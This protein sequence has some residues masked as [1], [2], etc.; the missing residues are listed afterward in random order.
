MQL[1]SRRV[2]EC[3]NTALVARQCHEP[4]R[5]QPHRDGTT[6]DPSARAEA[7]GRDDKLENYG[8]RTYL[9]FGALLC[10]LTN[11]YYTDKILAGWINGPSVFS[12]H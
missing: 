1:I 6:A 7:L 10:L 4:M 3:A 2:E 5:N 12:I 11:R 9:L 8:L